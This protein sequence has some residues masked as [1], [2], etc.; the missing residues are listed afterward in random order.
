MATMDL[1]TAAGLA[2]GLL[3]LACDAPDSKP[4]ANKSAPAG[5]P[6]PA[7]VEPDLEP[8]TPNAEDDTADAVDGPTEEAGETGETGETGAEAGETGEA[9]AETGGA[10]SDTDGGEPANVDDPRDPGHAPAGTPEANVQAFTRL[11]VG[12]DDGPPVAG[13]GAN[14][15][16]LDQLEVGKGWEKSRCTELATTFT[17][18][19]D[20][21]VSVCMRVIHPP[22]E[23]EELTMLWERDGSVRQRS[24]VGV[25]PIRAYLTRSWLP[26]KPGRKGSWVAKVQAPDGT[27][28]GEVKFE[29]E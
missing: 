15:I 25:K 20:D 26:V 27:I 1:R 9:G 28:L 17:A 22:G 7:K 19:V 18:G 29:I 12:K 14:G 10:D 4:A 6:A 11:P 2:L 5:D 23:A 21:R 13:I 8:A 3:A 24:K 16:H